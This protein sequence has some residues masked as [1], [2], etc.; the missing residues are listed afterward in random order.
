M[1][2]QEGQM[3]AR[4]KQPVKRVSSAL[5]YD[6][7]TALREANPEMPTAHA[8]RQ[9]AEELGMT[10][11]A[12][13]SGYYDQARIRAG[14]PGRGAARKEASAKGA[15]NGSGNGSASDHMSQV[16]AHLDRAEWAANELR[17]ALGELRSA[18]SSEAAEAATLARIR[19]MLMA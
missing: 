17:A 10:A 3:P 7:V 6:K 2:R 14:K 15:G 11:M 9:V 12:A 8:I 16:L 5:V 4:E 19:S 13:S 18:V 1:T